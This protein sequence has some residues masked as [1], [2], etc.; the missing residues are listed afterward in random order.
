VTSRICF[1]IATMLATASLAGVQAQAPNAGS[2]VLT[3][4]SSFRLPV[5]IQDSDRSKLKELKLFMKAMDLPWSCIETAPVDQ[6]SFSFRAPRDGEYSFH[7]ATVDKNDRMVPNEPEREPP[8]IIV[9][10]DT[11]PPVVRV[12]GQYA[13][14]G[15]SVLRCRIDDTHPDVQSL[16]LELSTADGW[17]LL[18]ADSTDPTVF[19]VAEASSLAGKVRVRASDRAG[20]HTEAVIDLK[21]SVDSR[22]NA[23]D[24]RIDIPKIV[25]ENVPSLTET[26]RRIES[27]RP[28]SIATVTPALYSEPA[29]VR[30]PTIV[31]SLQC[32]LEFGLPSDGKSGR[33][34]VWLTIDSGKSWQQAGEGEAKSGS[35]IVRFPGDGVFGYRLIHKTDQNPNAYPSSGEAPEG[36]VEVDTLKPELTLLSA[37]H[38]TERGDECISIRWRAADRNLTSEP[39]SIY[40]SPS[41]SAE[42]VAIAENIA[43]TESCTWK[44]PK[45]CGPHVLLRITAKDQ[46]GNIAEVKLKEPIHLNMG[47]PR[48]Q[49]KGWRPIP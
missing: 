46:A 22:S 20:N 10:V 7:I 12:E 48:V 4:N 33:V 41:R 39:I 16:L 23:V 2:R 18:S 45:G 40:Y 35:A 37:I 6:K 44:L 8:G 31:N 13:A 19:P 21:Q 43:N 27:P 17:R 49:V 1:A 42:W 11:T 14:N 29:Q 32:K 5:Q 36:S 30:G 25:P 24:H 34:E 15:Q 28:P 26:P 38:A 3:R 9:V 47:V